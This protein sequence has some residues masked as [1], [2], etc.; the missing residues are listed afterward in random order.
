MVG[1]AWLDNVFAGSFG[2]CPVGIGNVVSTGTFPIVV[3]SNSGNRG[4]GTVAAGMLAV[5]PGLPGQPEQGHIAGFGPGKAKHKAWNFSVIDHCIKTLQDFLLFTLC[6]LTQGLNRRASASFS[7]SSS[8]SSDS[9]NLIAII[10][11]YGNEVNML[12]WFITRA[13]GGTRFELETKSVEVLCKLRWWQS[14]NGGC[15]GHC[16]GLR[17][18]QSTNSQVAFWEQMN[19]FHLSGSGRQECSTASFPGSPLVS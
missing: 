8:S 4:D 1:C 13:F 17:D 18:N 16:S 19:A 14:S 6:L 11:K 7:S 15:W 12:K 10:F 2:R 5:T 3:M 9:L